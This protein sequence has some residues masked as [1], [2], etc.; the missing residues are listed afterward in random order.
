MHG[1]G[2]QKPVRKSKRV[3]NPVGEDEI[4]VEFQYVKMPWAHQ[5]KILQI[6][7]RKQNFG[8][9][10]E[11]G[12]GKTLCAIHL[13]RYKFWEA[14]QDLRTLVITPGITIKNWQKEWLEASFF[15]ET[16]IVPLLGSGKDRLETIKA[17]KRAV[18]FIANY[19]TL[20]MQPVF[21]ALKDWKP[22]ILIVDESQKAKNP[23]A[24]RTKRLISLSSMP[25]VKHR[26]ILSGT[27]VLNSAMDAFSQFL[28]LDQGDTWGTN[29]HIWRNMYFTDKN[30]GMPSH[31]HYPNYQLKEG[32]LDV[33]TREMSESSVSL[34][35]EDCLDLPPLVKKNILVELSSEQ[36]RLYGEMAKDFVAYFGEKVVVAQMALTKLLRLMQIV[37]GF[38]VTE[39][40]NGES[41]V[42]H[43]IKDN[44]RQTALAELLEEIT[45]T[46]KAIVW[47][48]FRQNYGQIRHV[49]ERLNIKYV[50][51]H[52]DV[53]EADKFKAVDQFTNDKNT[54]VLIG[55]AVSC[56]VG[57]NLTVAASSIFYS[58]SFSLEHSLQAEARSYRAGSEVHQYLTRY[59]IIA[60]GTVDEMIAERLAN[61]E[62]MSNKVIGDLARSLIRLGY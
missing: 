6:A 5:K 19:E 3:T 38:V 52:G 57:I 33:L 23:Q 10:L 21:Q 27:P 14:D 43:D 7:R 18:V 26:Y 58:R 28:I 55:N 1:Q 11:P 50:E 49:C 22:Q 12:C 4:P 39:G 34:K 47:A 30:A 13:A 36:R 40:D 44:P 51:I 61:K 8:L 32:A 29:F 46:G 42:Q 45:P 24:A 60:E 15:K 20:L 56:G 9:F 16:H 17:N 2:T 41:G 59:D 35:K 53:A 31:V 62:A 54:R 48:N 25:S 37:S